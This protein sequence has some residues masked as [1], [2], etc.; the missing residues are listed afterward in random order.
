MVLSMGSSHRPMYWYCQALV[1]TSLLFPTP[2]WQSTRN[3]SISVPQYIHPRA[4]EHATHSISINPSLLIP[5]HYFSTN[6]EG[7]IETP[8]TSA[9]DTQVMCGGC[10]QWSSPPCIHISTTTGS[11]FAEVRAHLNGGIHDVKY[12]MSPLVALQEAE[13]KPRHGEHTLASVQSIPLPRTTWR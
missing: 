6:P 13:G 8:P 1:H 4:Q 3:D 9:Y 10:A 12:Y 11:Q 5:Q 2:T 7:L